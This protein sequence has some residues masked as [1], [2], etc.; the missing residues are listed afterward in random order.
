MK[1]PKTKDI[2]VLRD[3]V[4]RQST[5]AADEFL[6]NPS[7]REKPQVAPKAAAAPTALKKVALE[8]EVPKF[9]QAMEKEL[10]SLKNEMAK[11]KKLGE[12]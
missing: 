1:K 3:H 12:H 8:R 5:S 7:H 6:K 2:Q 10:A 4:A 11:T 9:G